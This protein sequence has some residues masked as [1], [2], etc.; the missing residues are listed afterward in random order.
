MCRPL[1]QRPVVDDGRNAADE[2]GAHLGQRRH[3]RH[4][5]GVQAHV[6]NHLLPSLLRLRLPTLEARQLGVFWDQNQL[7]GEEGVIRILLTCG[8]D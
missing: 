6:A 4:H 2:L 7:R 1:T 8:G 3:R 5:E